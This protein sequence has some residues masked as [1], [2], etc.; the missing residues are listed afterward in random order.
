MP[1]ANI[2]DTFLYYEDT[3]RGSP[4]VLTTGLGAGAEARAELIAGLAKHHT[5][6][7]YDHRGTGRS[8]PASHPQTI[9]E[10]AD[11]I[12]GLMAA[13]HIDRAAVI[14]LSTGTGIATALA[15]HYPDRVSHLILGAPWTHGD[16]DLHVLQNTRMAAAR[17][18]PA[19][20]YIHF[21]SILI[22]PPEFRRKHFQRFEMMAAKAL[23]SPQDPVAISVRL[24]A[25]LAFDARELYKKIKC[26]TLVLGAR[27]DLVMPYWFA[28][29]AAA[30]ISNSRLVIYEHGGHMFPETRISDFLQEVNSFLT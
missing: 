4:I 26:P 25:I 27:D 15:G 1:I 3:G 7:T 17:T 16:A 12:V 6:L 13:A 2:E 23:K 11:D 21:N 8:G 24:A 9:E 30:A 29:D 20:F 18:M 19:D 5:V 28:Q 10:F 22:Y 14:G